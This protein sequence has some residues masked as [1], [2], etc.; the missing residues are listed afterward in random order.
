MF[1]IRCAAFIFRYKVK[2]FQ[3]Y[4]SIMSIKNTQLNVEQHLQR[5]A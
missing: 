5:T 2:L 4:H 1:I 3:T